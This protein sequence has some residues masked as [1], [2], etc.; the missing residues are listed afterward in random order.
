MGKKDSSRKAVSDAVARRLP[1]Y[2]RHVCAMEAQ[3]IQSVTSMQLAERVGNT[4][5]QVRQDFFACGGVDGYSTSVLKNWLG[6]IL[7]IKDEHHMVVVG[8]GNL[9]RAIISF[10]DFNKDNFFI[11]AVFDSNLML[12][13]MQINGIPILNVSALE[14]YLR[15]NRVDIVVI[16]TP[17]DFA[18]SILEK[19]AA[20]GV[21][22]VWNF[23]PA[24]LRSSENIKVQNVH[25]TESLMTL[26][27]RINE[28]ERIAEDE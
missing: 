20:G 23:A 8:A 21:K 14:D 27:F 12:E 4:S 5:A 24:D 3:G 18:Q 16:T 2:Y 1:T 6:T 25:L 13:G 7:G 15:E 10:Q 26:S 19:A 9:G 22:G 11:D 28:T 17:A